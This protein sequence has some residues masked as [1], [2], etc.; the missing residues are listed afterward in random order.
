MTGVLAMMVYIGCYTDAEHTNGIFAAE[1]DAR[2]GA[3]EVMTAYPVE[4]AIYLAWSP[5]RRWLYSCE[6]S[7]LVAFAAGADGKLV[8]TDRLNLGMR[9]ICHLSV[10][11]DGSRVFFAEYVAGKAGSVT[12]KDGKFGQPTVHVHSGSGPNLPRQGSAHCH[13]A[14]PS[15]DGKGYVVVDLGLDELVEYRLAADGSDSVDAPP[16]RFKTTLPGAGPRHFVFHP[17][18]RLAFL[19]SELYSKIETLAYDPD[20]GFTA[21]LCRRDLLAG[22][23]NGR[24]SDQDLAAAVR[25]APEGGKV[26]A[27]NRGEQ[28]LVAFGFDAKTGALD[29]K[30]RSVLPGSWPRDFIFLTDTLALA[31]MERSG[32]VHSL[33]YDPATGS[34]KVLSTLGGLHRPVALLK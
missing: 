17:D 15:P 23:G 22:G 8:E 6:R 10:A 28:S 11:A 30:A 16:R 3:M 32:E 9:C 19:V 34:F 27:S 21:T 14:V 5:D 20:R 7:G 33:R 4:N 25:L 12:V 13:Q 2:S 26:V 1:V 18:G 29:F 31:A 24:G